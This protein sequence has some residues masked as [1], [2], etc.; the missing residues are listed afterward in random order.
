MK[1]LSFL[2]TFTVTL[3]L[4]LSLSFSASEA[5]HKQFFIDFKDAYLVYAPG[6]GTKQVI[7]DGR[8]GPFVL[9]NSDSCPPGVTV[10]KFRLVADIARNCTG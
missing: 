4:V 8:G 2:M 7:A 6:S 3:L 10:E 5:A 1:K 9:A